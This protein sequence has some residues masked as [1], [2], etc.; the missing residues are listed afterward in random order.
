MMSKVDIPTNGGQLLQAAI[1]HQREDFVDKIF[2]KGCS[3]KDPPS[4][5]QAIAGES[6]ETS[7]EYR[8]APYLVQAA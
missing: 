7:D 2:K 4:A 6:G 5:V 1:M 3:L 8:K